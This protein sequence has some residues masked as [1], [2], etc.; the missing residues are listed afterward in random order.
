MTNKTFWPLPSVK[1]AV[2][3]SKSKKGFASNRRGNRFHCGTDIPASCGTDVIAIEEGIVKNIFLFTY[4]SLDKYN[5]Y[6]KSYAIAIQHTNGNYGV[7]CE[8]QKP[9]LTI[10]QKIKAGQKIAKVKRIFSYNSIHTMLH[11]EYHSKL[12]KK[13]TRWYQNKKPKGLLNSTKYLRKI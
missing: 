8:V 13:T 12:P 3:K 6:K 10:G 11:F 5:R 2:P 7:Y 1:K 4:P 9:K